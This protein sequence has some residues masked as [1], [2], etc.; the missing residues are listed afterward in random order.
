MI[1]FV[2]STLLSGSVSGTV[3]LRAEA[4]IVGTTVE[5]AEIADIRGVDADATRRLS[6]LT[7]G[8]APASGSVRGVRR[9]EVAALVR[10]AG[11]AVSLGGAAMCRATAKSEKVAGVELENAARKALVTLFAG[12]DVEMDLVRGA[13]DLLVPL[14]ERRREVDVDL[15]RREAQ[16]GSWNVPVDVRIDGTRVQTVWIA[17]DVKLFDELPVATRDLRRGEAVE[18]ACW[19]LQ[20]TRVDGAGPRSAQPEALFGATSARDIAAGARI[21]EFD[22]RRDPLVRSGDLVELEVVR[23]ALR[24][25][26]RAVARG[27][28]A[29]GDRVEVQSGEGQR[30][31]VGIVVERGLVRVDMAS[32]P[33]NER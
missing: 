26:C 27:Q 24:A 10:A 18:A 23:G 2:I 29:R 9:E 6:E 4:Q 20:R 5:L 16:P 3:N 21:T 25:R 32:S 28:G 31:L 7:L 14:A 17:L 22:V 15:G 33:R 12:R 8:P 11:V 30:R 19:S 1:A 13:S